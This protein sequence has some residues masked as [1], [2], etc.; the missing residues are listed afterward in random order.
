MFTTLNSIGLGPSNTEQEMNE[1]KILDTS[2]AWDWLKNDGV[3]DAKPEYVKYTRSKFMFY[4]EDNE[5]VKSLPT[6]NISY[7]NDE[8]VYF[9]LFK[10]LTWFSKY[11]I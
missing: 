1:I 2:K 6:H 4:D 3:C 11:L 5:S 7:E 9:F 10:F 8:N